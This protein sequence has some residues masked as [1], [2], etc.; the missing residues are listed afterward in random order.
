MAVRLLVIADQ[1]MLPALATGLREGGRFEVATA[2]SLDSAREAME[3]GIQAAVIFYG[4]PEWSLPAALQALL[5]AR[6]KGVPLVVVLQRQQAGQRDDCF[7]GGASDAFFMP[8]PK[9]QFVGRLQDTLGLAYREDLGPKV[10]VQVASRTTAA[11]LS[12]A[13]MT[14][15]GVHASSALP[16]EPG[17][18]V[19]LSWKA[20]PDALSA[21]GLV[22]RGAEAGAQVRFAG[23]TPE[24]DSRIRSWLKAAPTV[25]LPAMVDAAPR[26]ATPPSGVAPSRQGPI[27]TMTPVASEKAPPGAAAAE[28]AAAP[29]APAPAAPAT[30]PSS[31]PVARTTPT[32]V[33][34]L[35]G[36]TPSATSIVTPDS[37]PAV[38]AAML[39]HLFDDQP[40]GAAKA[41]P[42][43]PAEAAAA[44][45]ANLFD[46]AHAG[47]T[48]AAPLPAAASPDEVPLGTPWPDPW[49]IEWCRA[50]ALAL[51][52]NQPPPAGPEGAEK[53]V[54]RIV[55]R[56]SSEQRLAADP[57]GA[58]GPSSAADAL[59]AR[60]ALAGAEAAGDQLLAAQSPVLVDAEQVAALTALA[61][62]A[63]ERL[64]QE[65]NAA[66]SKGDTESLRLLTTLRGGLSQEL[67]NFK[68]MVDHLRGLAAAPALG[69]GE[70]DPEVL[71]GKRPPPKPKAPTAEQQARRAEDEFAD[72]R[73]ADRPKRT[74]LWLSLALCAFAIS[75]AN[76]FYFSRPRAREVPLTDADRF[77]PGVVRVTSSVKTAKV[78]VT[79]VW[80]EHYLENS[81]RLAQGLLAMNIERAMLTLP[82]GK[83]AGIFDVR[84]GRIVAV[85]GARKDELPVPPPAIDVGM[86][87]DPPKP[88]PGPPPEQKPR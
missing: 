84:T 30:T 62:S 88:A 47:S 72:F 8:I 17:N 6:D 79:Q 39:D 43:A 32:A 48:P 70:L 40:P 52:R 57:P 7:R 59:L 41:A 29:A 81:R 28:I 19:R 1:K 58:T 61:D 33:P 71:I 66:I 27:P 65:A 80:L 12:E 76:A 3:A 56:T 24:E 50:A 73:H 42:P 38:A 83:A 44:S 86:K 45:L 85:S 23:L 78:A 25:E 14:A 34:R 11:E 20:G 53:I 21:W 36:A 69:A 87:L 18:T 9:D 63:G 55:D 4:T 13:V 10:S 2:A 67:L 68:K 5:P 74:G 37:S 75:A 35:T 64:Q 82:D 46:E 54:R 26:Q 49:P 15:I 31:T 60:V 51:L 16:F 22:A 77:G